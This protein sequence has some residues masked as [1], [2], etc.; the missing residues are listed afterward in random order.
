MTVLASA[1][2]LI[3][4]LFSMLVNERQFEP[5]RREKIWLTV[6]AQMHDTANMLTFKW[7]LLL[8]IIA[9]RARVA[10]AQSTPPPPSAPLIHLEPGS[11]RGIV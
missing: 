1:H 10:G 5:E 11:V 7:K 9:I 2:K 3:R 4:V 6:I 8:F